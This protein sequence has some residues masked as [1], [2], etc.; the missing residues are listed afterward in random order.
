MCP[1][2]SHQPLHA[3]VSVQLEYTHMLPYAGTVQSCSDDISPGSAGHNRQNLSKIAAK[4]HNQAAKGQ[5]LKCWVNDNHDVLQRPVD[6]LKNMYVH[7]DSL[8]PHN[9]R[10]R[11]QKCYQ[12][13]VPTDVTCGRVVEALHRDLET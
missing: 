6:S 2:L 13:R 7:H 10:N 8:I 11:S 9:E 5:E 3:H 4:H 1:T 12:L